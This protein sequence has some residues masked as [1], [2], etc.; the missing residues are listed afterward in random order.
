MYVPF[1]KGRNLGAAMYM[2]F[3]ILYLNKYTWFKLN[4]QANQPTYNSWINRF[5]WVSW[6]PRRTAFGSSFVEGALL[7]QRSAEDGSEPRRRLAGSCSISARPLD[8]SGSGF[9]WDSFLNPVAFRGCQNCLP[10]KSSKVSSLHL[11]LQS[12]RDPFSMLLC[13]GRKMASTG[14]RQCCLAETSR[15][16]GWNR[17]WAYGRDGRDGTCWRNNQHHPYR[18]QNMFLTP[19]GWSTES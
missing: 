4:S 13:L 6:H 19:V 17:S 18:V 8:H 15:F 9:F 7:F 12:Q 10:S 3:I 16:T 1:C 2:G 5:A 14:Y 11:K